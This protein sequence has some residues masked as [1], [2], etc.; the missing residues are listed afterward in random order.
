MIE[1]SFEESKNDNNNINIQERSNKSN[2]LSLLEKL[3]FERDKALTDYY[4]LKIDY[5][6]LK[7]LYETK[8]SEISALEKELMQ[9]NSKF[10]FSEQKLHESIKNLFL[11]EKKLSEINI[12]NYSL[13]RKNDFLE[14]QLTEYKDVYLDYKSRSEKEILILKNDLDEIK[15]EKEDIEKNNSNMKSELNKYLFK[16]KLLSQENE[17]LKNDNDNLI[18]ILEE[19]NH[20]VKTAEAK[21]LS[22]DNTINVYKKQISE[23][24]L[25]IEKLKLELKMQKEHNSKFKEFFTEKISISDNNFEL[26]LN[27]IRIN[28][29]KKIENKINEY[30]KL[31]AEFL[32]AKIERDKYQGEYNIL[33]KDYEDTKIIFQEQLLNIKKEKEETLI[34]MNRE[35]GHL[36]DKLNALISQNNI[37]KKKLNELESKNNELEEEKNLKEKLEIKNKEINEEVVKIKQENEYLIKENEELKNKINFLIGEKDKN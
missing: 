1:N 26:A 29:H 10:S 5:N 33:N 18:K 11:T 23:L 8:D 35:I 28:F 24:N 31:K 9:I 7:K 22:L 3:I 12:Q 36:N 21:S 32:N 15:K 13:T 19:H 2:M 6:N 4:N 37:M 25:E 17:T 27:E 30:N 20:I 14:N 34:E 16:N